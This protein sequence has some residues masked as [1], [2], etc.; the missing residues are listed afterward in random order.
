MSGHKTT[1]SPIFCLYHQNLVDKQRII[2][3]IRE[4]QTNKDEKTKEGENTTTTTC[5]P[6]IA[7]ERCKELWTNK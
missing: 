5:C 7:I 2:K 6:P 4:Q 1:K 3:M